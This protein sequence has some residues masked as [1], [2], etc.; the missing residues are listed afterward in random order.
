M[1]TDAFTRSTRSN[2]GRR[3]MRE[4][5]VKEAAGGIC[6]STAQATVRHLLRKE[7]KFSKQALFQVFQAKSKQLTLIFISILTVFMLA[8]DNLVNWMLLVSFLCVLFFYVLCS[9]QIYK[10][11]A[12]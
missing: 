6:Y 8:A 12:V 3:V 5:E 2:F 9:A 11:Y 1:K 4:E 7:T 10:H